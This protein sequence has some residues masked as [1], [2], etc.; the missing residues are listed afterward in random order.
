VTCS[1]PGADPPTRAD[2]NLLLRAHGK[3]DESDGRSQ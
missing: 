1:R 2:L 3:D